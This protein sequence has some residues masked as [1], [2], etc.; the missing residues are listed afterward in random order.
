[1][2]RRKCG[3]RCGYLTRAVYGTP[4]TSVAVPTTVAQFTY[5]ASVE[6]Q[7]PNGA[8]AERP[9]CAT[10][11]SGCARTPAPTVVI[12]HRKRELPILAVAQRQIASAKE[13]LVGVGAGESGPGKGEIRVECGGFRTSSHGQLPRRQVER[14]QVVRKRLA[15]RIRVVG[16]QVLCWTLRER[17]ALTGRSAMPGA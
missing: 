4:L 1:M 9:I 5:I 15:T 10:L 6:K 13:V 17:S 7:S 16:G 3:Y 2:K 11:T 8:E 14:R 12:A